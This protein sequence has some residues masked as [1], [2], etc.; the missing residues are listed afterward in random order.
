MQGKTRQ[1]KYKALIE[2]IGADVQREQR[3]VN[4]RMFGVFLWCFLIP[5]LFSIAVLFLVKFHFLPRT[6]KFHL[7][8]LLLL[9]PVFYSL[10]FLGS[11][12]LLEL[13]SAFRKGGVSK[14]LQ[15][16]VRECEWRERIG[17]E[18][19]R[20]VELDHWMAASLKT[21]LEKMKYRVRYLTAL[22]GAVF[23]LIMQGIDSI[24]DSS[25][26]EKVEWT[27]SPFGLIETSSN[28]LSQFVGLALFL[29]L[30]YLSG[31]QTYQSLRRYSD[32]VELK[33]IE[34]DPK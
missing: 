23:F 11:E 26:G 13:P 8:W 18:M 5:A 25:V 31:M 21:D 4:R 28:D 19:K 3:L 2:F 27:R 29:M 6:A 16:A 34:L 24:S 33:L 9:F 14:T 30:L 15:Q 20:A 12:V 10:Y 22:G 1:E 7:D 17:E 32:C